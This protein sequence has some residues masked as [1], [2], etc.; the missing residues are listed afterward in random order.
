MQFVLSW[1]AIDVMQNN[2]TGLDV[3][4]ILDRVH[5][6]YEGSSGVNRGLSYSMLG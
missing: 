5:K 2:L 3:E 4:P 1:Q 6:N